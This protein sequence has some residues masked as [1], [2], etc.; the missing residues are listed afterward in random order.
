M[1]RKSFHFEIRGSDI[2]HHF[3]SPRWFFPQDSLDE[4]GGTS[5]PPKPQQQQQLFVSLNSTCR[6]PKAHKNRHKDGIS[7]AEPCR[8][9]LDT[10]LA[11]YVHLHTKKNHIDPGLKNDVIRRSLLVGC[12]AWDGDF[13]TS[14]RDLTKAIMRIPTVDRIPARL[15]QLRER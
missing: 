10:Y 15:H 5:P 9:V 1:N 7:N 4:P 2:F 3:V 14:Y 11:C 12:L 13:L 8:D 6:H